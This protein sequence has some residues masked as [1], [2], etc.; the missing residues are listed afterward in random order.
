MIIPNKLK[1]G[2]EIRIIAPSR[3]WS[4][5]QDEFLNL[6]KD[7]LELLWYKVT[8]SKNIFNKDILW[9]SSIEDRV[10]DLHDAF[11]DSCVKAI[12]TIIGWFNINTILNH[13]DYNLIK[14]NPKILCGYSDIT[15]LQNALWKKIW[16]VTYSWPHFS[17]WAM[18]KWFDYIQE[19]F[20]NIVT[21][22]YPVSI[23]PSHEYS[24]DK[25]HKD[26]DSRI[27]LANWWYKILKYWISTWKIIWGNL[28]TLNLLQWTEYMPDLKNCIV[29]I[30]DDN[31]AWSAGVFE[32]ERNFQS[33]MQQKDAKYIKWLLIGRFQKDVDMTEEK[34]KYIVLSKT[35]WLD[36]PII[37][38]LDFWH[39]YPM[40]T[41]PIWGVISIEAINEND[42]SL[43]IETH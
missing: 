30:E 4:I 34:L 12:I 27:F 17:T 15:A 32:F 43:T 21:Q 36:I 3:S 14:N 5:F 42:I 16:L 31:I 26:Q 20:L 10:S 25:W 1:K 23:Y 33:L 2:D 29:F 18:K 37:S 9:S 24:E 38:N 8:F 13:L 28:C 40:I 7:K 22:D 11:W 35:D 41:F 6:A 19:Y 39:T